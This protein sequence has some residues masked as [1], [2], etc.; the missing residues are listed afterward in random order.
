VLDERGLGQGF[1][2]GTGHGLGLEVHELPRISRSAGA[3]LLEAGMICTI[4]PGV[5]IDGLGGAR[6]EDDVLVTDSGHCVLTEAS[7]DL[8]TI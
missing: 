6:L 3:A 8:V 2:H 1:L 5:Y 7:R 4:E